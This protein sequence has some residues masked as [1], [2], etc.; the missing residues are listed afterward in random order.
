VSFYARHFLFELFVKSS[1][2]VLNPAA[3]TNRNFYILQALQ[4]L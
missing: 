1:R 4:I 2:Q 3:A